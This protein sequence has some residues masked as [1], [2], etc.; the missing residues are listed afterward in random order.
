MGCSLP[1]IPEVTLDTFLNEQCVENNML[2]CSPEVADSTV[3]L[4]HYRDSKLRDPSLTTFIILP[5]VTS[6]PWQPLLRGMQSLRTL[7]ARS[8]FTSWSDDHPVQTYTLYHDAPAVSPGQI[9]ACALPTALQSLRDNATS[10]DLTFVFTGKLA[11]L[12]GN[13]LWDSGSTHSY[14]SSAFVRRNHLSVQPHLTTS[15]TLADG[16][17][18]QGQGKVRIKLRIQGYTCTHSFWVIDLPAGFDAILGD[19]WSRDV[20]VVASYEYNPDDNCQSD[21]YRSPSLYLRRFGKRLQPCVYPHLPVAEVSAHANVIT[22]A[23]TAKLL[24]MPR[25]GRAAFTVIVR[26][27]DSIEQPSSP[28]EESPAQTRVSDMLERYSDVFESPSE[29]ESTL[30]GFTPSCIPVPPDALPP[31]RPAFR[32]SRREREEV[33]AQVKDG[34]EKG[35]IAPSASSYGAPVLFVPKP[36]GS[37]RMCIDYRALNNIT[38]KNKYPLP[39]IDDLLDNLSGAK[40]FSSLDLTSGY[41]QL[42]LSSDDVPKTAFNTHMGKYEWRVLPF[43]LTKR[44]SSSFCVNT[45]SKPK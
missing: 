41:H 19:S 7:P 4:Q 38:L 8:L 23:K 27:K 34:L 32:L 37:M 24:A 10:Q 9:S 2:L 1:G 14:I 17:V 42:R 5:S 31:N 44:L 30:G 21:S 25:V 43:G 28:A 40:H 13:I 39:R 26:D 22:A 35:W 33:E 16:S 18:I 20:G 12:T 3:L 15:V 45:I 36:D 11:G 29:V 6:A